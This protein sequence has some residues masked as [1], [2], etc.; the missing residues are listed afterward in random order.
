M[1]ECNKRNIGVIKHD[2]MNVGR[3][4]NISGLHLNW[5]GINIFI[6]NIVF[7]VN[8]FCSNW[9]VTKLS[10]NS[11]NIAQFE[12]TSRQNNSNSDLTKELNKDECCLKKLRK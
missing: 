8:K 11:I 10:E 9:L 7:Y 4:S 1:T 3:H 6:E 2:N 5:K 12:L